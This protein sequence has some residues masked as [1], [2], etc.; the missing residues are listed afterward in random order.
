[1]EKS[2]GIGVNRVNY[3]A[4]KDCEPNK[5]VKLTEKHLKTA[6]VSPNGGE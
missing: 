1:M 4:N 6:A 5:D 2:S 3:N